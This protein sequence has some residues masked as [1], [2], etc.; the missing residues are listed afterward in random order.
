MIFQHDPTIVSFFCGNSVGCI[1][2]GDEPFLTFSP[3][4][5]LQDLFAFAYYGLW[6]NWM[7]WIIQSLN[8]H[9]ELI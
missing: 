3:Y 4:Q 1:M 9:G 5:K 6:A 7:L 8:T 2:I